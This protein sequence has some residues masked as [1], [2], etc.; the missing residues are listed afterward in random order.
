MHN[1]EIVTPPISIRPMK[2]LNRKR[3]LK[4]HRRKVA[5]L[6]QIYKPNPTS[7]E[8]ALL[9]DYIINWAIIN[10][11]I[12]QPKFYS[13]EKICETGIVLTSPSPILQAKWPTK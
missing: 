4:N 5:L 6:Y 3:R 12:Q 8:T 10:G 2:I 13:A 7:P 11:H 9:W 1:P